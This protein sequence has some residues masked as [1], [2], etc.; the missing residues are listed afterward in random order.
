MMDSPGPSKNNN[1]SS[2]SASTLNNNNNDAASSESPQVQ[3]TFN[4]HTF[5]FN[6]LMLFC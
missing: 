6:F 4:I 1:G 5:F 3:V 2:S